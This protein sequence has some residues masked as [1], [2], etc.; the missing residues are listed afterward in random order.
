[1]YYFLLLY[2]GAPGWMTCV[3]W[4]GGEGC[5]GLERVLTFDGLVV[6]GLEWKI[7]DFV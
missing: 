3:W 5:V 1:V 4:M 2:N 7:W 6:E